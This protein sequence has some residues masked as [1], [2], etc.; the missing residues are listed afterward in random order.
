MK[1]LLSIT[2]LVSSMSAA[3]AFSFGSLVE[4]VTG[5]SDS[6]SALKSRQNSLVEK[7]SEAKAQFFKGYVFLLESIGEKNLLPEAKE[8]LKLVESKGEKLNVSEAVKL[9]DDILNKTNSLDILN[10]PAQLTDSA[11]EKYSEGLGCFVDALKKELEVAKESVALA[12]DAKAVISSGSAVQ[13]IE[14]ATSFEP[15]M[16]L[17]KALPDDIS[18]M[19]KKI[20]DFVTLAK[21]KDIDVPSSLMK[22]LGM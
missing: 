13:R 17:A 14:L 16:T 11:K 18:N 10:T 9:S 20:M 19:K 8:A 21:K 12:K 22:I 5:G 1:K 3:F 6:N 7:Y 4:S 2:F 15:T